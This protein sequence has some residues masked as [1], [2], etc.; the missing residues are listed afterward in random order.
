M[1]HKSFV[2]HKDFR[3]GF[4]GVFNFT[5][6]IL[7]KNNLLLGYNFNTKTCAFLRT[8]VNGFRST[9]PN[10]RSVETIFDTVTA[11]VIHQVDDKS[12]AGL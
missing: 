5:H 10:F 4:L 3:F 2:A 8:E 7:Q 11:D 9:N 12:K 1:Y 6:K